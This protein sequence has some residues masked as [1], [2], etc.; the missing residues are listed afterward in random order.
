M[1]NAAKWAERIAQ[2]RAS[3]LTAGQFCEGQDFAKATLLWWSSRLGSSKSSGRVASTV[4][5]ARVVCRPA[6]GAL[7]TMRSGAPLVLTVGAVRVHVPVAFDQPTLAAVLDVLL[8]RWT[9]DAA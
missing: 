1:A 2:W 4:R 9:E 8:T 5:I 7:P 6:A 3:G